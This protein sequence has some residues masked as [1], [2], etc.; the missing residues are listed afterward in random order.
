MKKMK[1]I[2]ALL[3]CVCCLSIFVACT[4]SLDPDTVAKNLKDDGYIVNSIPADNTGLG[5]QL[6]L[7]GIKHRITGM[8][9]VDG[10]SVYSV[11]INWYVSE[12]KAQSAYEDYLET[13]DSSSVYKKGNMVAIGY[14]EAIEFIKTM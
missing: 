5:L 1:P 4:S 6:K 14:Y 13:N 11:T 3:L 10:D 12:S 8:K 7:N 9:I 2:I